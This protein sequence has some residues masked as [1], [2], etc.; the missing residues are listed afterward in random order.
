LAG[1]WANRFS[2]KDY[3]KLIVS[4]GS[5]VSKKFVWKTT[6][7]SRSKDLNSTIK[8]RVYKIRDS[9]MC[10]EESV[11]CFNLS[12]TESLDATSYRDNLHFKS[13]IYTKMN[14]QFVY[15]VLLS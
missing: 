14:R 10:S 4:L 8:A 9:L 11:H 13:E 3:V 12:W 6:T 1:H 15:E 7:Y 5:K 2:D